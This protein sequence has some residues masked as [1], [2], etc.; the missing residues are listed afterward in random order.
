MYVIQ[1]IFPHYRI[2]ISVFFDLT[3]DNDTMIQMCSNL[4]P[5]VKTVRARWAIVEMCRILVLS[6]SS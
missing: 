6:I 1:I 5:L 3:D 2:I 4:D